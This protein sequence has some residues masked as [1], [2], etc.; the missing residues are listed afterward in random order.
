MSRSVIMPTSLSFSPTGKAPVSRSAIIW[1]AVCSV[2]SGAHDFDIGG[3]QF[4]Y[5]HFLLS[6]L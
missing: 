1:A 3:H 6:A 2:S 5:F 4:A